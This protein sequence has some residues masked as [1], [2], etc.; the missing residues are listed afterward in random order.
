[1]VYTE[2]QH[3]R[4]LSRLEPEVACALQAYFQEALCLE[5][6]CVCESHEEL[7][8]Y[9]AHAAVPFSHCLMKFIQMRSLDEVEVYKRAHVDRKHFSKIR[10]DPH[11]QPK[12]VT[13]VAFA[14]A[15][16]LS[17]QE[18]KELLS[19]AG[20]T[21]SGHT[22]FDLIIRFF[23]ERGIYDL[24]QMLLVFKGDA[25][26]INDG[27]GLYHDRR[28]STTI[29]NLVRQAEPYPGFALDVSRREKSEGEPLIRV[30]IL[31]NNAEALGLAAVLEQSLGVLAFG[32]PKE[33]TYAL[34]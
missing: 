30:R 31:F 14:L 4:A 28:N 15:L 16:R 27:K 11:Y 19:S 12:K 1:M 10:S 22:P 25:A 9:L 17:L 8:A 24:F 3:R 21:L 13:V 32:V 7:S 33:A 23:V 6:S 5:A 2:G 26:A 29:I 18:T 20:Y 34:S